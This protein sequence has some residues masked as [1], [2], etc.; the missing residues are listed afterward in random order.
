MRFT[1]MCKR[2][3]SLY[4]LLIILILIIILIESRTQDPDESGLTVELQTN[5]SFELSISNVVLS[6]FLKLFGENKLVKSVNLLLLNMKSV[7]PIQKCP[8]ITESNAYVP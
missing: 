7:N 6:F 8:H 1:L 5:F 2:L 3:Y 4:S